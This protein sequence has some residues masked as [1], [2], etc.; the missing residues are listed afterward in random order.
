MS[1]FILVCIS[2]NF[3]FKTSTK[4]TYH[5]V[6]LQFGMYLQR[7]V[8]KNFPHI[9]TKFH[10][11]FLV[12][13]SSIFP[14]RTTTKLHTILSF[15]SLVCILNWISKKSVHKYIPFFTYKLWY[16]LT[17]DSFPKI[18]LTY[19]PNCIFTFW[20]VFFILFQ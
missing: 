13:I 15:Y 10:I 18:Q 14:F 3:P 9:H 5:F 20:Y 4:I 1:I 17:E 7:F 19:I 16:V 6:I 11:P 2:S 12:C 8:R